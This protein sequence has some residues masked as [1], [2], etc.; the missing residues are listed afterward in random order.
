M[1]RF[2]YAQ[3]NA[4]HILLPLVPISTIE[5][6]TTNAPRDQTFQRQQYSDV[7]ITISTYGSIRGGIR[8]EDHIGRR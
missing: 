4:F 1:N 5:A 8:L 2:I 7:K 6:S 3:M